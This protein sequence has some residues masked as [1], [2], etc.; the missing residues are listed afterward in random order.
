MDQLILDVGGYA[1]L[2]PESQKGGYEAWEEQLSVDLTMIP[3]NM[4]KEVRGAVWHVSYQYGWFDETTKNN[5]L[6][7]CR[8][9]QR[10]PI[11]CAF[12]P[13]NGDELQTGEFFVTSLQTPKFQWSRLTP[14]EDDTDVAVPVW[15]DFAV[16]LREVEPHD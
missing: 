15:A 9:G 12:L 2:M 6:A 3:G 13:P 7:A 10:E 16:E 4:V 14:G 8:K 1:V 11:L 5:L